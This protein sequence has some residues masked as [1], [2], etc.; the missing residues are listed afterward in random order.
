LTKLYGTGRP[1]DNNCFLLLD[2]SDLVP[3]YPRV[4]VNNWPP[5]VTVEGEV[6]A[7]VTNDPLNVYGVADAR[8]ASLEIGSLDLSPAFNKSVFVY[9]A[10][11]SNAFDTITAVAK[12]GESSISI[13]NGETPVANGAEATW[14]V[15]TNEVTVTVSRGD[16]TETYTV[17]VTYTAEA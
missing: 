12:D 3:A 1:F 4:N 10:A 17:T 15:G 8:L 16:E 2:I 11:T 14:V 5:V 6:D 7:A 13:K 9:T